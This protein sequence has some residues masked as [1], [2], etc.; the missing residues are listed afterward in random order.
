M[1]YRTTTSNTALHFACSGNLA[2][3]VS[4]LLRRSDVDTGVRNAEGLLAVEL[5]TTAEIKDKVRARVGIVVE[6]S[7]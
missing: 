2:G 3:V 7:S 5:A 6:E 1:N 4:Q